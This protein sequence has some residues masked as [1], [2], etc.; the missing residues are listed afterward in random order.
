MLIDSEKEACE[1]WN[2]VYDDYKCGFNKEGNY[3]IFEN[4]LI[5]PSD[6]P[7]PCGGGCTGKHN[8][9]NGNIEDL[10]CVAIA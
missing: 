1:L 6:L 2:Q 5:C 8:R 3:W 7:Y 4:S 10:S 9:I